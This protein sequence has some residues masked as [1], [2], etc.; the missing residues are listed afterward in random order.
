MEDR[1]KILIREF[2]RRFT[3]VKYHPVFMDI[4]KREFFGDIEELKNWIIENFIP[5]RKNVNKT[6]S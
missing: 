5:K 3:R 1:M 4:K 6:S 2:Y